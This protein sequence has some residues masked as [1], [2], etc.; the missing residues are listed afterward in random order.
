MLGLSYR[1]IAQFLP[2]LGCCGSKS[3]VERDVAMVG[4]QAQRHHGSAPRMRLRVL[5]ADG[6]G[7]AMPGRS[8]GL[9]FFVDVERGK[10]LCVEP[11]QER[12]APAVREHVRRVMAAVGAEELRTDELSVYEGIV[13]EGRHRLCLT[14]CLKSKC[15]RACELYRQAV[16]QQRPLEAMTLK[17][18]LK[19]L[20]LRPR[21]PTV[22]EALERL[23][24]RYLSARGGLLGKV[25]QFLQHVERT[26]EQV[27][28][29]PVDPTNNATERVIGLTFKIRAKTMR[30]FKS[31]R[32]ALAHAYLASYLR[33]EDGVCD[34]TRIV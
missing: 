21:P 29:D 23:V 12:D 34:L 1:G 16:S 8:S 10:L 14:H 28:D 25:N 2:C 9:L 3:A 20:R 4:E 31:D 13:P 15:K 27:S 18:L 5:G 7:G 30:G 22:P 33:G 11:V 26:W 17:E 6:T 32:K 24:R 19:W